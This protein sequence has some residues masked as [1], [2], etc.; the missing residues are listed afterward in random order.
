MQ[1]LLLLLLL[2]LLE[3]AAAA[4][5]ASAAVLAVAAVA[6][7][8]CICFWLQSLYY[9]DAHMQYQYLRA[10]DPSYVYLAFSGPTGLHSKPC[11]ALFGPWVH[12]GVLIGF[13]KGL[14]LGPQPLKGHPWA[15]MVEFP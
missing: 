4:A 10:P 14:R 9:M 2:V 15:R 7:S 8:L 13:F 3:T 1:L 12:G 11:R 5:A 6:C